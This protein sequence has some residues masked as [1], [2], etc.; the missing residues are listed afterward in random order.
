MKALE[1]SLLNR[2]HELFPHLFPIPFAA[3]AS[4]A[5]EKIPVRGDGGRV[6]DSGLAFYGDF[7]LGPRNRPC[8][9]F[10]AHGHDLRG[11]GE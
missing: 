11:A 5:P 3:S 1:C 7:W 4:A 9:H 10:R 8:R 6:G 2:P